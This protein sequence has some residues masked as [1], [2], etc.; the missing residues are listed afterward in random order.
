MFA[1]ALSC[2]SPPPTPAPDIEATVEAAVRAA[3][4]T[5]TPTPA[6]DI[7]GT[8]Q[9]GIRATLEAQPTATPLPTPTATPEPTPTPKPTATPNPTPT[10]IAP[11]PTPTIADMVDR[12]KSGVVR[13]ETEGGSGSGFIFETL[14]P[15]GGALVLTNYH[16]VE[17]YPEVDVTVD[18]AATY[19][20]RVLGVD[21]ERDLAVVR[22]C[23]GNFEVLEFGDAQ[24]A[25]VGAEVVAVGYPLDLAGSATVTKGIVSANRFDN[26]DRRWIIQTDAPINPGNSG[27]PLLASDGSVIGINTFKRVS[28]VGGQVVEGVGFAVS[29]VTIQDE[30]LTLKKGRYRPTPT[31]EPREEEYVHETWGYSV[32][33]PEGWSIELDEEEDLYVAS[34][35]DLAGVWLIGGYHGFD[36]VEELE[37]FYFDHLE[38]KM[39]EAF[40]K[41]GGS[42][43]VSGSGRVEAIRREF[44]WQLSREYCVENKTSL[45]VLTQ[46]GGY[47]LEGSVC[48]GAENK[49]TTVIDRILGSLNR[50]SGNFTPTPFMVTE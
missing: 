12:V 48:E 29:E 38:S 1:L 6:P 30:L 43:I 39:P 16:V 49:H 11:T 18:D 2:G 41:F 13:I 21:R 14:S 46:V 26:E 9:A 35:D 7:P 23:C 22:I 5:P 36:S 8:V 25:R 3:L 40:K 44:D 17:G 32:E 19:S 42:R 4:P 33:L 47:I 28:L 15:T 27:G 34:P 10:Q 37:T 20:G 45:T 31:P 50:L 24:G